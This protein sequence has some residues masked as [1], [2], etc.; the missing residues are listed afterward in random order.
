MLTDTNAERHNTT[1]QT[2]DMAN[3]LLKASDYISGRGDLE[4]SPGLSAAGGLTPLLGQNAQRRAHRSYDQAL[5]SHLLISYKI[6][7]GGVP[8]PEGFPDR[9]STSL[10]SWFPG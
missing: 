2:Q 1:L 6:D 10:S 3:Q 7:P 4:T 5:P 8:W 9:S